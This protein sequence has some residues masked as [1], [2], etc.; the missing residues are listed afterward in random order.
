MTILWSELIVL[1]FTAGAFAGG[2]E[3]VNSAIHHTR[4][5][6]FV[7]AP[8]VADGLNIF[9]LA[10]GILALTLDLE[11]RGR[12]LFTQYPLHL[13]DVFNNPGSM[14]TI[15]ATLWALA[16]IATL[17][18]VIAGSRRL[19]RLESALWYVVP[20][21]AFAHLL[22]PPLLLGVSIG[23][24]FWYS[25]FAPWLWFA[26][27]ISGGLAV[28]LILLYVLEPA[29]DLKQSLQHTLIGAIIVALV[30]QL[31]FLVIYLLDVGSTRGAQVL[32]TGPL[33]GQF[34]VSFVTLGLLLPLGILSV[35][36]AAGR[37][38]MLPTRLSLLLMAASV[39]I[40]RYLILWAGQI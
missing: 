25:P 29:S 7:R 30:G 18:R 15:G 10:V 37:Y 27:A 5:G 21:I 23:K 6:G 17:L 14:L 4:V 12:L 40:L 39:V 31:L 24:P 34:W 9:L 19:G 36:R 35:Q 16:A 1:A 3:L 38:A 11:I 22:Y 13:L 26:S 2:L 32:L 20:V 8:K 28:A 33:A